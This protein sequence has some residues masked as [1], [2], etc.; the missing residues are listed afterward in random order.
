MDVTAFR[1]DGNP[2]KS[3]IH[4][5]KSLILLMEQRLKA[6]GIEDGGR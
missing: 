3:Q 6:G 5:K 1:M 2:L 4:G